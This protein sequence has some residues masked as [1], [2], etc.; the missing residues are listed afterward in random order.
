MNENEILKNI[1]TKL[2]ALIALLVDYRERGSRK[3]D[4]DTPKIEII[5]KEAGLSTMEIAKLTSKKVGAV[6]KTIQRAK[7]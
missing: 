5:L 1:D 2:A 6:H 7:K 3:V 4:S